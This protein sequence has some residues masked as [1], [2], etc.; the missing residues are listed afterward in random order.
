M[1][2]VMVF[3]LSR[4]LALDGQDAHCGKWITETAPYMGVTIQL[5]STDT[6]QFDGGGNEI[7]VNGA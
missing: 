2:H 6:C 3:N 5:F 4:R 1:Q 7:A